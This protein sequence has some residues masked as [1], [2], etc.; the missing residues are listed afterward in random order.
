MIMNGRTRQRIGMPALFLM[1]ALAGIAGQV[2]ID[3]S[4]PEYTPEGIL[5]NHIRGSRAIVYENGDADIHDLQL[6]TFPKD[7]HNMHIAAPYCRLLRRRDMVTSDGDV[8]IETPGLL[9]TGTGFRWMLK[10]DKG[11]IESNVTVTITNSEG[12]YRREQ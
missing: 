4:V 12:L 3:F 1:L 8:R 9:I 2:I 5:K 7:G 6:D 10:E 11:V